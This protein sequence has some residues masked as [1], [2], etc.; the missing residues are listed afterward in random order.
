VNAAVRYVTVRLSDGEALTLHPVSVYGTRFVAYAVPRS[1][2]VSSITASSARGDMASTIPFNAPDATL[3]TGV[4]LRPGQTGMHRATGLAGSGTAGGHAWSTTAY[5]GPWGECL[6][7]RGN[8]GPSSVCDAVSA[9]QGTT[10]L[11][12]ASGPLAVVYGTAGPDVRHVIITLA[13]GQTLRV[14]AVQVGEQRF[15]SYALLRGQHSVRWQSFNG[16]RHQTGSSRIT[17]RNSAADRSATARLPA[18]HRQPSGL[19]TAILCPN[20][21]GSYLGRSH[22]SAEDSCLMEEKA[23]NPAPKLPPSTDLPRSFLG[24]P[25]QAGAWA[26]R[27]GTRGALRITARMR[28]TVP[29][30]TGRGGVM[31]GD[32]G[33]GALG[34]GQAAGG[35][36][37]QLG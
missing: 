35:W 31:V 7:T 36:G 33:S 20:L 11:G 29:G 2:Q 8:G 16:A 27:Q 9:P 18:R 6:V 4:W 24:W 5:V 14:Q 12:A 13:S 25:R 1:L 26:S 19:Q 30:G 32:S 34:L 17:G 37:G 3:D 22:S 28:P 23:S 10:V 21:P 15:F